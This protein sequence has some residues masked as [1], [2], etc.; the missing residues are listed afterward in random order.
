[1]LHLNK[2]KCIAKFQIAGVQIYVYSFAIT[3]ANRKLTLHVHVV[4]NSGTE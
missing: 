2:L 4:F 3:D 1:M